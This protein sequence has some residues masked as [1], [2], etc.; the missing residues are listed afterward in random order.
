MQLQAQLITIAAARNSSTGTVVTVRGIVS[1]GSE[2]GGSL[3]YMQ[4]G[5]A[6][7]GA[8]S[9]T[10]S[11][12]NR[13]DSIEV[14]GTI[15]PYNNLMEIAVTS[16]TVITTGNTPHAPIVL[17]MIN[18]YAEQYE[19]QLVR[20]NSSSFVSTG[21]FGASSANYNVQDATLASGQYRVNA[22]SNIAGT[23]IPTSTVDLVGIMGQY[24]TSYQLLPRD[25]ND[26]IFPGNPP[27]FTSPLMQS[28][29][30]T[31]GFT[32]SFTTQSSGNSVIYY[33]LTPALGQSA[34]SGSLVTYHSVNLTGL[35]PGQ[36]YYVKGM[37]IS[38]T[39]DTSWSALQVMA[40]ISLSSQSINAYFNRPV[41]TTVAH[42][43]NAVYLNNLCDDTLIAYMNRAKFTMDIC[44]YNM[45]NINGIVSAINAAAN[46]GVVVRIIGDGANMNSSAWS[47]LTLSAANKKL[48]PT[49]AAYGICHNKFMIIDANSSNPNDCVLW[50]GSMNWTDDQ[51][52]LDAN[53]VIIFQDQSI[54]R[55]YEIEFNEMFQQNLFGPDKFVANGDNTAH[56]F[57]IGGNRVQLFFSPTDDPD[58]RIKATAATVNHDLELA[59][60][61]FTR[62]NI[63]YLID[64]SLTATSAWGGAVLEDTTN[65][66]T[67]YNSIAPDMTGS[68]FLDN[69]SWLMHNK[70]MLVDAN[71]DTSDPLVLTG[72]HNWS[73]SAQFS[74]DENTVIVHSATIA[75][76]YYQNWVQLYFDEGGSVL[77]NPTWLGEE[78]LN[79]MMLNKV[80]PNPASGMVNIYFSLDEASAG[81]IS[82][83]NIGGELMQ[84]VSAQFQAGLNQQQMNIENLS[85]GIY[86][87]QLTVN[88]ETRT[89]KMVVGE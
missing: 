34:S 38:A 61:V 13:G 49:S 56:E 12:V 8:Y 21:T 42:G 29:L 77:P 48:S 62:S 16:F 35:T 84:N 4:D 76:Q 43:S 57:V 1:N 68:I 19:G 63:A 51:I 73:T 32:V 66:S 26:I 27:V 59:L 79:N 85:A 5:T 14:T 6:G 22:A 75:N 39:N 50:T 70:Y 80:Y 44:I 25:L 54:A 46:R 15:S 64:D 11:N 17:T 67:V 37:S 30:T 86:M 20:F 88:H 65:G 53:N 28:N 83:Y 24:T 58:S 52:K 78:T 9:T 87:I 89:M 33:G 10:L 18:G 3:R 7:I 31:T 41:N 81:S 71:D 60:Y 45:D 72:S 40:D 47:A 82:I 74:N 69:H 2:F 23:P 36:V 55:A